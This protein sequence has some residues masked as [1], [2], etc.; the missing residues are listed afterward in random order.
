MNRSPAKPGRSGRWNQLDALRAI[1]MA[2]IFSHHF[3]GESLGRKASMFGTIGLYT[4]LSMSGFLTTV[5]LLRDRKTAEENGLSL[6]SVLGQFY[7][8]R[9]LR[10]FPV[11]Y[12][13]I[14]LGIIFDV[15]PARQIWVW[16]VTHTVNFYLASA[17]TWKAGGQFAHLWS[18][19]A[20]EHFYILWAPLVLFTPRKYLKTS[21][22]CLAILGPLYRMWGAWHN[23]NHV[24]I[25]TVSLSCLDSLGM[26]A[27]MGVVVS[28]KRQWPVIIQWIRWLAVPLGVAGVSTLW[29]HGKGGKDVWLVPYYLGCAILG[30]WA[31]AETVHGVPG[32]L[33]RILEWRWL[34]FIGKISYGLYIYHA[35]IPF[36]VGPVAKAIGFDFWAGGLM[37]FAFSSLTTLIIATFSWHF[38]ES[39]IQQLKDR[40]RPAYVEPAS[41]GKISPLTVIS[42]APNLE[43][44]GF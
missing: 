20:Q 31:I 12:L 14:I 30:C 5:V 22:F 6:R 29:V 25:R 38:Y 21:I 18:L 28:E 44:N 41:T 32:L 10:L 3:A 23:F 33:G 26:G 7:L 36:F 37:N 9:A 16:L 13:V 43:V 1:A 8:R 19:A 15:G 24:A 35:F 2:G 40:F 34:G 27:L 17:G 4:F 42:R 39:P 11:F